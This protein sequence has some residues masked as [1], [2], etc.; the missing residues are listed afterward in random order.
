MAGAVVSDDR[1]RWARIAHGACLLEL[2]L[3][4]GWWTSRGLGADVS[5]I[6][7]LWFPTLCAIA[8][9]GLWRRVS[10]GRFLFS[11]VSL[12]LCLAVATLLT[13]DVDDARRDGAMLPRLLGFAPPLPLWWAIVM[14]MAVLP[15]VPP[16]AIGRRR[17]WFRKA[18]W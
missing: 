4:A 2:L 3:L 11:V 17:H 12:L 8:F 1:P 16:L 10:W 13:P 15:L 9:V 18:R 5:R 14:A 6:R 7:L